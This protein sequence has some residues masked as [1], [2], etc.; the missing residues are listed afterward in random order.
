[1]NQQKLEHATSV[2]TDASN[3]LVMR[4]RLLVRFSP[5]GKPIV[6]NDNPTHIYEVAGN[7]DF[8]EHRLTTI[9]K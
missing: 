4:Y 7:E 6:D 1:M 3:K 2:E 9:A 5:N 8:M